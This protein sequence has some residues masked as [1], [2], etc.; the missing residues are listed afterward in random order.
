MCRDL[1]I[2]SPH[3]GICESAVS[4][5]S[6]R[7]VHSAQLLYYLSGCRTCKPSIF[8]SSITRCGPG[9]IF[10]AGRPGHVETGQPFGEL[11][12]PVKSTHRIFRSDGRNLARVSPGCDGGSTVWLPSPNRAQPYPVRTIFP[13]S[14]A[15]GPL[16]DFAYL[17]CSH[18]LSI[19][20]GPD[21]RATI[22]YFFKQTEILDASSPA[23][24]PA[25]CG[26][27]AKGGSATICAVSLS[28]GGLQSRHVPERGCEKCCH[29]GEA[30]QI[31]MTTLTVAEPYRSP[32]MTNPCWSLR[33]NA[34]HRNGRSAHSTC[35]SSDAAAGGISTRTWRTGLADV[36]V[37]DN[38]TRC[39]A[40]IS[41]A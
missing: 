6:S 1:C 39:G 26:N 20:C 9:A 41:R 5:A 17:S 12:T 38:E 11:F 19:V 13:G 25:I 4:P 18:H 24:K 3:S 37:E 32:A 40:R 15:S 33:R 8:R 7:C 35:G 31:N 2:F 28:G 27:R 30:C 22:V 14:R 16:R 36:T 21:M 23:H 29:S 34:S 10:C